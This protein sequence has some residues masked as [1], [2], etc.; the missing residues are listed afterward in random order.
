LHVSITFSILERPVVILES[1]AKLFLSKIVQNTP[2]SFKV[3]MEKKNIL[4]NLSFQNFFDI[5]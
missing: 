5:F 3:L 4:F 1:S 2:I